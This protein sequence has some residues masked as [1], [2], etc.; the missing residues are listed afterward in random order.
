MLVAMGFG[1][2]P[3]EKYVFCERGSLMLQLSLHY[4][5]YVLSALATIGFIWT[6]Q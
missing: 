4:A 5:R 1:A 2:Y 3:N 6:Q